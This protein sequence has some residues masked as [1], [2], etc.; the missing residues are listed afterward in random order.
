MGVVYENSLYNEAENQAKITFT[1]ETLSNEVAARDLALYVAS[2][3]KINDQA[4]F[5]LQNS[6][7]SLA[8][9]A[10]VAMPWNT[11]KVKFWTVVFGMI[12][13]TGWWLHFMK[14]HRKAVD[15]SYKED[16]E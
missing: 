8:A 11:A 3:E 15:F 5:Y 12:Y 14:K 4:S 1:Y 10:P 2:V 7:P 9:A 13:F 16:T 6:P